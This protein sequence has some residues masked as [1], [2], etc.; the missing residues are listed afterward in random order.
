MCTLGLTSAS[1]PARPAEGP[2]L[3]C[4]LWDPLCLHPQEDADRKKARRGVVLSLLLESR[5]GQQEAQGLAV[6]SQEAA[7][8][9]AGPGLGRCW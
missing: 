2:C 4:C 8:P 9:A 1:G 5:T 7:R 3:A 6:S